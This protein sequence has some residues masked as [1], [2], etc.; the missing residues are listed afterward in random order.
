MTALASKKRVRSKIKALLKF[1]AGPIVLGTAM[2]VALY[3][4]LLLFL[5]QSQ[6]IKSKR[7]DTKRR[8]QTHTGS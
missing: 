3:G 1:I 2:I 8:S 7:G 4:I 6:E 5:G